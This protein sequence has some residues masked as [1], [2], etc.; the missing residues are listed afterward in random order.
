MIF[1]ISTKFH[2]YDAEMDLEFVSE[3]IDDTIEQLE[4]FIRTRTNHDIHVALWRNGRN[5][6]EYYIQ[7]GKNSAMK[8]ERNCGT[9]EVLKLLWK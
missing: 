2:D 9:D 6:S 5:I 7:T 4:W 1:T 8:F 3:S